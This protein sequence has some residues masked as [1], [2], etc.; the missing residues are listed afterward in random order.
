MNFE[1]I[2][3]SVKCYVGILLGM[4]LPLLFAF[5]R[6]AIFIGLVL[7]EHGQSF[8]LISHSYFPEC[9]I[10]EVFHFLG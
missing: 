5:G 2:S 6:M 3:V 9:S 4:T 10:V 7:H 8:Y 1:I